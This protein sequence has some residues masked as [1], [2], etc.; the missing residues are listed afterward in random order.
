MPIFKGFLLKIY[1]RQKLD[2]TKFGELVDL[3]SL[4]IG[5][6]EAKAQDFYMTLVK[7][8]KHIFLLFLTKLY[9]ICYREEE[10]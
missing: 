1:A 2:K 8:E 7:V 4:N 3:F 10:C 6:K 5:S 9:E